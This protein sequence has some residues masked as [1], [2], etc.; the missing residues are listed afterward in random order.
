MI[1]AACKKCGGTEFGYWTSASTG[2]RHRYCLVCRRE[3]AAAY[4]QRKV[5]N[6]GKH[7]R[8]QWLDKLAQYDSCPRCGRQWE[9]IPARPDRRYKYVWTKDHIV[10]LTEGGTD[11]IENIQPLCFQCNSAKCNREE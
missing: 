8:R 11:D 6:G 3:R 9:T 4:S 2:K 10:P 7:T 5:E 1:T